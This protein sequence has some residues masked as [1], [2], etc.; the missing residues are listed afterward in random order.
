MGVIRAK[1]GVSQHTLHKGALL[2]QLEPRCAV[3]QGYQSVPHGKYTG[4]MAG[5]ISDMDWGCLRCSVQ[6]TPC[7]GG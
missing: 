6:G 5:I 2:G 3:G 4:S 1:A 7:Q